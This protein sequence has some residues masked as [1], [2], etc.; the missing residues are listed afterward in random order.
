M[1][2]DRA[3][4]DADI[5]PF[6][7]RSR[8]KGLLCRIV[9]IAKRH[10]D[11]YFLK[12]EVALAPISVIITTLAAWSYE[13]CVRTSVYD[14]ELDVLYDVGEQVLQHIGGRRLPKAF[15]QIFVQLIESLGSCNPVQ[16]RESNRMPFVKCASTLR[17]CVPSFGEVF[18]LCRL[19]PDEP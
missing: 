4:A 3:R 7:Q 9:Q 6:P 11:V 2:E 5:E 15:G 1:A 16:I 19:V 18:A 13:Y 17:L 12:H 8:F 14:S 10:R